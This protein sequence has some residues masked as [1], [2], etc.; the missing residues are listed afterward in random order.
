MPRPA[1]RPGSRVPSR[2]ALLLAAAALALAGACA[3]ALAQ[4][5]TNPDAKSTAPKPTLAKPKPGPERAGWWNDA[6]FYHVFVRSFADSTKGALANDG[7]GDFQGLIER[8]D[9]LNDG[10]P[11]TQG[12]LGISAIW[13]M[14]MHPS[15][16]YHGYDVLDYTAVNPQYGSM[17]DFK[18]FLAACNDRGIRVIIDLV[19]NHCSS[20]HPWFLE[21]QDT[22][23][24]KHNWF[25]W[26][27]KVP[28]W[29]GPWNQS[30]WHRVGDGRGQPA[31][32]AGATDGPF[33]YG[34]FS[35]VMPDLNFRNTA[36]S[37]AMLDV[38]AFWL[39]DVGVHGYRLDAIRHLVEEGSLQESAPDTFVWLRKFYRAVKAA[40]PDAFTIGEVWA[41]SAQS[42]RYV[43][44][45]LDT[46]FDFDLA[47]AI[48]RAV[49]EKDAAP[50]ADA[51]RK[52]IALYPPNQYGRFL[53]NHD[54]TRVM[55]QLKDDAQA[56]HL[57][58]ALLLTGPGVPF[59]YYGEELGM[60]GD[61]PDE[62]IRTPMQWSSQPHSGFT[63]ATPWIEVNDDYAKRNVERQNRTADSLLSTYRRLIHAR[64][65]SPALR[66]GRTWI[67]ETGTPGVFAMLRASQD[68]KDQSFHPRRD[69]T[70]GALVLVNLTDEPVE[71]YTLS[72]E[73]APRGLASAR[74]VLASAVVATPATRAGQG[75]EVDWS[76]W[77][78]LAELAPRTAY[79]IRMT[80]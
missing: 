57:A 77:K 47:S 21:A 68:P 53:S 26:T 28:E 80:K 65:E 70:D 44:G 12:D 56:M 1:I 29:K 76:A 59:I 49:R 34:I 18:A 75:R 78:P 51:Q 37:D 71:G 36:A 41:E 42:A 24:S 50:L 67:V 19:L 73:V 54:Q 11:K 60:L 46:T 45:M 8:L 6:V 2:R 15:P 48:V 38:T 3:P 55:T 13:L 74:E 64:N 25:I 43:G 27:D 63:A 16:S 5:T 9:Y 39:K 72:C 30:V 33:Y 4:A 69:W 35:P 23:S 14:P 58:A 66:H 7:I 10:D 62:R 61:K 20:Q 32:K 22:K 40:N 17:E 79:V 52:V 31:P